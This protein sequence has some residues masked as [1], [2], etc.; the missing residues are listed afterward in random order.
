M[1]FVPAIIAGVFIVETDV[2]EDMRGSFA[3]AFC[4]REFS[5]AGLNTNWP[6]HNF[7][8]NTKRGTMRG[9]HYQ[10]PPHGEIKLIRC[11]SGAIFDV[12]VDVREN[13][14]TFG[15]WEGFELSAANHRALYVPDGIAHGFQT[16]EDDSTVLYLMSA[17]YV[18]ASARG[19]AWNDPE[20]NIPWPVANPVISDADRSHPS[21]RAMFGR[22]G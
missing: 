12:L 3:R 11:A 5:A 20:L 1:R 7:S 19:I 21:L 10:V 2:S 15:K 18:P 17:F 9:L 14:P 4:E 8:R 13:S 16:L 6:Q 22:G